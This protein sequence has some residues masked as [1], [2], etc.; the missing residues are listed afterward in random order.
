MHVHYREG[1]AKLAC[2]VLQ[3][4]DFN[5]LLYEELAANMGHKRRGQ[6]DEDT[7]KRKRGGDGDVASSASTSKKN[8]NS[9]WELELM[10]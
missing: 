8:K 10:F 7:G 9:G 3:C 4:I 1:T 2:V 6:N 5:N